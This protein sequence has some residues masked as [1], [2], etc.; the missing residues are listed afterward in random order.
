MGISANVGLKCLNR[1]SIAAVATWLRAGHRYFRGEGVNT[2]KRGWRRMPKVKCR[3]RK[4]CTTF[5][6]VKKNCK[7]LFQ[8]HDYRKPGISV[9]EKHHSLGEFPSGLSSQRGKVKAPSDVLMKTYLN[10]ISKNT[11]F[12]CVC[13]TPCGKKLGW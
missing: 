11:L 7:C 12:C 9:Q 13:P 1:L 5:S 2:E 3:R 8:P 6:Y 4:C 10:E